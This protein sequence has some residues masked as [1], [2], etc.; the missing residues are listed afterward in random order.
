MAP[1]FNILWRQLA[2]SLI[3][4]PCIYIL[5][6][7]RICPAKGSALSRNFL[8]EAPS[9]YSNSKAAV[10]RR[11]ISLATRKKKRGGSKLASLPICVLN[12]QNRQTFKFGSAALFHPRRA[13]NHPLCNRSLTT[14]SLARL[15]S[16]HEQIGVR[17]FAYPTFADRRLPTDFC[18]F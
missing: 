9:L 4:L 2:P 13:R 1:L 18:L 11:I 12:E 15:L 5:L 3:A 6:R 16:R 10:T 8:S 14:C 7:V 17:A